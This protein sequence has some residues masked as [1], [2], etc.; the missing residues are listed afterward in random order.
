[1]ARRKKIIQTYRYKCSITDEEFKTTKKASNPDELISVN[2]YYE[3]N[4]ENDDRPENI[5]NE[6][7]ERRE[8]EQEAR[9]AAALAAAERAEKAEK[10]A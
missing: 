10:E 8:K 5:K 9:E 7:V 1:M 3:M 4:P 6:E 2:A